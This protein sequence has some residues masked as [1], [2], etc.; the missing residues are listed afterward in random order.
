[1]LL[2]MA[3]NS[4]PLEE[5]DFADESFRISEELDS[6]MLVDSL[7]AVGQLNPAC[8]LEEN[9]Q[10]IIVCG[11]RRLRALRRLGNP[12]ALVRVLPG[13]TADLTRTFNLALWD[14]LSH[15]Q[16]NPLEKARVLS[17]LRNL[18]DVPEETLLETYL[19]ILGL[20]PS[21]SVLRAYV[22]LNDLHPDL[23]RCLIEG[24]LTQSSVEKL[25]GTPQESQADFAALM[26]RIRL[27]ASSQRKTLS[28]LE[29]LAAI[30]EVSLTEPLRNPEVVAATDDLRLSP[31]QKGERVYEVLYRLR[32][33]RISRAAEQFAAWKKLLGLPGSV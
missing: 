31:F 26:S 14:N 12:S 6:A 15:R 29:E 20:K 22:S 2:S 13:N 10:K 7:R 19:P 30:A 17:R 1:M 23:R 25:A 32:N 8:V 24:R 5:I 16:L 9:P 3:F 28:L 11:F 4:T 21:E 18:C 27:S 33:L